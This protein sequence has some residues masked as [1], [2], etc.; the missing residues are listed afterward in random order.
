MRKKIML[1]IICCI[2]FSFL[3]GCN[4]S[5]NNEEHT[6]W[7][8]NISFYGCLTDDGYYF[9]RTDIQPGYSMLYYFDIKTGKTVPVCDKAECSH[10]GVDTLSGEKQV[11]N[12]QITGNTFIC[13]K[14]K[15]YYFDGSCIYRRDLDGNNDEKV[16]TVGKGYDHFFGNTSMAWFY[17]DTLLLT[18]EK[19]AAGTFDAASHTSDAS[20][21][22]LYSINLDNGD[23]EEVAS[24]SVI[25]NQFEFRI[26]K[27]EQGKIHFYQLEKDKWFVYDTESHDLNEE[28]VKCTANLGEDGGYMN[29]LGDYCYGYSMDGNDNFIRTS[30]ETDETEI[31][32]DTKG[33]FCTSNTW[34]YGCTYIMDQNRDENG[35]SYDRELLYYDEDANTLTKFPPGI[36]QDYRAIFPVIGNKDG[37]VYSIAT[38]R[39]E[40]ELF[41]AGDFEYRYISME[42]LLDGT[43]H[44][45][46]IYELKKETEEQ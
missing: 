40:N 30:I 24:S 28:H 32:Y 33:N 36:Y 20:Q 6:V 13:F 45:K 12:A 42:D 35:F 16:A 46:L 3:I 9:I 34:F 14:D 26:Y 4:G 23:V 5:D 41:Y 22:I 39:A 37:M 11:C 25:P 29:V 27:S 21:I 2:I 7:T 8:T 43:D 1:T 17:R 18:M 38:N 19:S 15:I 31:C 44:S 10:R